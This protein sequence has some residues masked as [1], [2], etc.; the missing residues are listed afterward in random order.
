MKRNKQSKQGKKGK[1]NKRKVLKS[2]MRRALLVLSII[3]LAFA[4]YRLTVVLT[5]E[6]KTQEDILYR[7]TVTADGQ[8]KVYLKPNQ[9][10]SEK[11]LEEN[12]LYS[13]ALIEYLEVGFMAE[14]WGTE[15][16]EVSAK[17]S[18]EGIA[19]GYQGG[20]NDRKIIYEQ[21]FPI[22]EPKEIIG[23]T[24]LELFETV[25][26]TL[27][28]Y[29]EFVNDAELILGARS[30]KELQ[31]VWSGVFT[32]KTEFGNIEEPFSFQLSMPMVNEL[33]QI[34]KQEPFSK[35]N[36]ISKTQEVV[37]EINNF[38]L[39]VAVIVLVLGLLGLAGALVFTR[40][41]NQDE[42][43]LIVFADIVRK[44]GSRIIRMDTLPQFG[45]N[46][47]RF[48]IAD[49]DSL[50]KLSDDVQKPICFCPDKTGMP[51]ENLMFVMDGENYYAWKYHS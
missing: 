23:T 31:V 19:L 4:A 24:A 9:L 40:R 18:V 17:Y 41:P 28:P 42:N 30:S 21:H 22:A 32:A 12:R 35:Q 47:L 5:P 48:N 38:S 49:L 27:D 14:F 3:L 36:N 6:V 8:Y 2:S 43:K 15:T 33:F 44:H 37:T 39:A 50:V 7:Y 26:V 1:Q 25:K 13:N 51:V 16:A 45:G 20:T 46:D 34:N 11:F 10:Y 29:R